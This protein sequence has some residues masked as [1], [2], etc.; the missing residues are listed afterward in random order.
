MT[1][2]GERAGRSRE[3]AQFED[4]FEAEQHRLYGALCL[5]THDPHE[6]EE[7]G[8]EAFVRVL[9]RWDRVGGMIDPTGYL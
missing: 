5:I 3:P 4:L 1:R 8:Q 9:E 2:D 7:I 6:A